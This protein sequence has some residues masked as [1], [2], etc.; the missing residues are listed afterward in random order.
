MICIGTQD[1]IYNSILSIFNEETASVTFIES[2]ICSTW[3]L[4]RLYLTVLFVTTAYTFSQQ[5]YIHSD[6]YNKLHLCEIHLAIYEH[7]YAVMMGYTVDVEFIA[8][9]MKKKKGIHY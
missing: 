7:L 9:S 3:S 1:E 2:K 5:I 4:E 6:I 8:K